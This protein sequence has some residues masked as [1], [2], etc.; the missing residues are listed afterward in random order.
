MYDK[1]QQQAGGTLESFLITPIQRIPRYVLLLTELLKHTEPSHPDHELL[2][3]AIPLVKD[4]AE[5]VNTS[6]RV[7]T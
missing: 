6:M 2:Q 5:F 7:C 4:V 1:C 3:K